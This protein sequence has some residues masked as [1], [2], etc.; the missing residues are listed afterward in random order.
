VRAREL[1][2][3]SPSV[4]EVRW[5]GASPAPT[6]ICSP[7]CCRSSASCVSGSNGSLVL[8]PTPGRSDCGRH[9]SARRD[10][11]PR[12]HRASHSQSTQ[13]CQRGQDHHRSRPAL[14]RRRQGRGPTRPAGGAASGRPAVELEGRRNDDRGPQEERRPGPAGV[15]ERNALKN[16]S[17]PASGSR[18]CQRW[19]ERCPGAF[20]GSAQRLGHPQAAAIQPSMRGCPGWVPLR[21]AAPS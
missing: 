14:R 6:P 9:R 3:L 16:S 8:D 10:R 15:P 19:A 12:A 20:Q 1:T 13:W 17:P 2:G 21:T 18:T 11:G 7:W 4:D 5:R